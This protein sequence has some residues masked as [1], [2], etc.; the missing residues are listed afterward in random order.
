MS[1]GN[2]WEK[3]LFGG[4]ILKGIYLLKITSGERTAVKKIVITE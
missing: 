4:K 1:T 2:S 3:V